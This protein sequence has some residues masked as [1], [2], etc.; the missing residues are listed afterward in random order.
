M[1]K[2]YITLGPDQNQHIVN[3]FT[4]TCNG[5]LCVPSVSHANNSHVLTGKTH[6]IVRQFTCC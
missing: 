3:L 1:K 5:N 4:V 2:S 6:V